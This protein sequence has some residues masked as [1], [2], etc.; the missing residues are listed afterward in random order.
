ML[1]TTKGFRN[2][3]AI[4]DIKR[5]TDETNVSKRQNY[6]MALTKFSIAL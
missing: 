2:T 4:M 6:S 3:Q 5:V 1:D